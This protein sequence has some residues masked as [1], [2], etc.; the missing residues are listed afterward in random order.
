MRILADP[1][2]LHPPLSFFATPTDHTLKLYAFNMITLTADKD[3]RQLCRRIR[4]GLDAAFHD[5]T[6]ECIALG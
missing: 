1:R 5:A 6:Q 4:S 2:I 3:P